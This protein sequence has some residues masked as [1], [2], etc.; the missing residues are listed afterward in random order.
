MTPG[1]PGW[2]QLH[3]VMLTGSELDVIRG[4]VR[5]NPANS[6]HVR[7]VLRLRAGEGLRGL[8]TSDLAVGGTAHDLVLKVETSR[9]GEVVCLV[10]EQVDL[11]TDPPLDVTICQCLTRPERFEYTLQKCTEIGAAEFR[12]VISRRSVVRRAARES[13]SRTA[14]WRRI[15]EEAA[16]QAGRGRIPDVHEPVDLDALPAAVKEPRP[17]V[18]LVAYEEETRPLGQVLLA[19]AARDPAAG[20][21]RARPSSAA[22]LI[23]PEGGLD[24]Q[25]V[26]LLTSFG[27]VPVSLGPRIL[28]AETAGPVLLSLLLYELGDMGGPP[29]G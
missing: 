27:F 10:V 22:I 21:S 9:P 13:R 20:A 18:L 6:H 15:V 2:W 29:R 24:P 17:D 3:R 28:R 5:L 23:G 19:A 12:P 11:G 7:E 25:E 4:R 1:G 26:E 14:R 16:L 8:V